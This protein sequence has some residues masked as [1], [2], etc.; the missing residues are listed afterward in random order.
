M[1]PRGQAARARSIARAKARLDR[2]NAPN[3]P[4]FA[5]LKQAHPAFGDDIL[6]EA[7]KAAVKFDDDCFASYPHEHGDE[8][9]KAVRAVARARPR[10]SR[11][12]PA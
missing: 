6:K 3:G 11:E 1:R 12:H 9:D 4:T 10:L 2:A 5:R 7:I 8:Q